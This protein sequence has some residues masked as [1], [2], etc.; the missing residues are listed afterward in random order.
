MGWGGDAVGGGRRDRLH[1]V[2][3]HGMVMGTN[4]DSRKNPPVLRFAEELLIF[5][6]DKQSGQLT[7][8]SDS[9]LY[10]A[11]AGTVLMDLA[12]EDRIDTDLE[13]LV[14]IDSTPLNDDLLDPALAV[15][16]AETGGHDTAHWIEHLATPEMAGNV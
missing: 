14:L 9:V 12:L 7:P 3:L 8:V 6:L 10:Y 15:I 2:L 13:R 5:L 1:A 11:L 4:H 16:A